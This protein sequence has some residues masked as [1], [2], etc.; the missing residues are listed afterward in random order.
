MTT[1]KPDPNQSKDEILQRSLIFISARSPISFFLSLG[2]AVKEGN[3]F[4][5]TS[6]HVWKIYLARPQALLV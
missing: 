1:R 3:R 5:R 2:A 4:L 6:F